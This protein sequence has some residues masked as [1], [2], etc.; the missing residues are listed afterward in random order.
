ME[1]QVINFLLIFNRIFGFFVITPIFG[2][3]EFPFQARLG[4]SALVALIIYPVVD[5]I[6]V[7]NILWETVIL[8]VREAALG[9]LMGFV[10]FVIFSAVYVCGEIIDLEMGFGIVSVLDPQSNTQVPMLGNFFYILTILVFL[11][12]NGHHILLSAL[13]ESYNVLPLGGEAILLNHSWIH[14][15]LESFLRMF[16]AGI[17]MSIPVVSATFLADFA[18]G[19]IARTVPQMNVFIV[20]LP[21]KVVVGVIFLILALPMYLI[22]LDVLFNG[23]YE[24]IES[25]LQGMLNKP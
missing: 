6:V 13:I 1:V 25:I 24:I 2:R 23:S 15:I 3:R 4:L 14:G 10:T 5:K 8:F 11:T 20:G 22:T 7:P 21:F 9:F 18:L 17:K 19:I 12:I 16:E